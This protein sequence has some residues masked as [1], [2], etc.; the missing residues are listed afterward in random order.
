MTNS[1]RNSISALAATFATSVVAA[2]RSSN[3]EDIL[4]LASEAAGARVRRAPASA[5]TEAAPAPR[6]KR[7]RAKSAARAT[8]PGATPTTKPVARPA[9]ASA[10][11]AGR[12]AGG[13]LA[14]RSPAEIAKA[15]DT[16][17]A[18]LK[19]NK[20]GLRSEQLREQLKM[21]KKEMP[22]VL[23]AGLDKKV[24]KSKGQKRS[25]VYSTA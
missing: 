2:I 6:P 25:T 8:P 1:L 24:L 11:K 7:T 3:L 22:R 16:I 15:L 10:R 14:R 23:K 21:D 4:D 13:R 5:P 18:V 19:T 12:H 17:L 9:N 20:A